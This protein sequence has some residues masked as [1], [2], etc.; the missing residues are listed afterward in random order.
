MT[1]DCPADIPKGKQDHQ[2]IKYFTT[3]LADLE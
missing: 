3:V 2:M 1:T